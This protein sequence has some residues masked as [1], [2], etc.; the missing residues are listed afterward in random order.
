MRVLEFGVYDTLVA[1]Y[2]NNAKIFPLPG[3]EMTKPGLVIKAHRDA[4]KAT[5]DNAVV[6]N[7]E[8]Y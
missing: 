5:N 6:N 7:T 1:R 8:T 2:G 3:F 4:A